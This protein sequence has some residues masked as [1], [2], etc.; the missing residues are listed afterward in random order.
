MPDHDKRRIVRFDDLNV[1]GK[2]LFLTG[3]A[4]R[5]TA[6]IIDKALEKAVD[7]IDDAER[8]FREGQDS[9]IEDAKILQE[10][11]EE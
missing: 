11:D 6:L 9:S 10:W 5:T 1:F 2:A 3:A 7:V 8:A 4:V